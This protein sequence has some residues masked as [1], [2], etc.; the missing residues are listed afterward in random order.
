MS[1]SRLES[2]P[3]T[4]DN[5]HPN[6][7][8]TQQVHLVSLRALASQPRITEL[9]CGCYRLDVISVPVPPVSRTTLSQLSSLGGAVIPS[10]PADLQG[11]G[12]LP[13]AGL[14]NL[15]R[16]E[17]ARPMTPAL[18]APAGRD[19]GSPI[20][21]APSTPTMGLSTCGAG[22]SSYGV[23]TALPTHPSPA[24]V[25]IWE[26]G[27]GAIRRVTQAGACTVKKDAEGI[28]GGEGCCGGEGC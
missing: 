5:L 20:G 9:L 7:A 21:K 1:R 3:A 2:E 28:T 25:A 26:H 23:S 18:A 24:H 19:N 6:G 12:R 17:R 22:H 15:P 16:T 14:F 27:R 4:A 8:G 13:P 10:S 11:L